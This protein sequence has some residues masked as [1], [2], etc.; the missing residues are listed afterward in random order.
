MCD[1]F[2]DVSRRK[3]CRPLHY[4]GKCCNTFTLRCITAYEFK[5]ARVGDAREHHV[6]LAHREDLSL[7]MSCLARVV[8]GLQ[9]SVT[10]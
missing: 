8:L 1:V 2:K 3:A 7:S 9:A 10:L 5:M 6:D 4:D